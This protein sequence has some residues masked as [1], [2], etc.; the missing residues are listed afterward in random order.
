MFT[1][2]RIIVD[3]VCTGQNPNRRGQTLDCLYLRGADG[4]I[5]STKGPTAEESGIKGG[6]LQSSLPV[7]VL[8]YS[9]EWTA[10]ATDQT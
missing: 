10:S 2:Q 1:E 3:A 6:E 7:V 8:R 4:K 9:F 5:K